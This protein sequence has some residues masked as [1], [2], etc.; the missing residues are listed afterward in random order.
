M[1]LVNGA[2]AYWPHGCN[3]ATGAAALAASCAGVQQMRNILQQ[4]IQLYPTDTVIV[5]MESGNNASGR[6]GSLLPSPNSN[7]NSGLFQLTN[8][9]GVPQE[10]VSLCRI[11]SVRVTSETY[12]N[13]SPTCQP[14]PPRL[15]AA[16]PTAKRPCALM[17]R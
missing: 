9:Q 11:A 17:H 8:A 13:A 1:L 4:I 2:G 12:N 6:P 7:P 16:T 15:P 3:R 5:A 10:A 14:Q